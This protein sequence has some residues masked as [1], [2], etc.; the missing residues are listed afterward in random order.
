MARGRPPIGSGITDNLDGSEHARERLK[1]VLQTI[2]GELT[3]VQACGKLDMTEAAFYRM[4]MKALEGAV[5]GLEPRQAGRPGR[6][7]SPESDRIAELEKE[8]KLREVQLFAAQV[9]EE[10]ALAMPHLLKKSGEEKKGGK[11]RRGK[12]T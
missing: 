7:V 2:T 8:L 3:I 4:R 12:R 11:K 1:V 10:I 5:E 6:Q 9:R